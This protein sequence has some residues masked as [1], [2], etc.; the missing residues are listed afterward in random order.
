V[1]KAHISE[2]YH[3]LNRSDKS[4]TFWEESTNDLSAMDSNDH[5]VPE[6]FI[7]I[8]DCA[9][10]MKDK[11][12]EKQASFLGMKSSDRGGHQDLRDY[13]D[14][15]LHYLELDLDTLKEEQRNPLVRR[16]PMFGWD[17][18]SSN[19]ISRLPRGDKADDT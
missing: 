6:S 9:Y 7:F 18:G 12:L 14:L 13:F 5:R 10:M 19:L 11:R 2:A 17:K 15:R 3:F 16:P 4:K 8:A 1:T